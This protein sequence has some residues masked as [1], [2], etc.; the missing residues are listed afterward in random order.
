[1]PVSTLFSV[2]RWGVEFL[3]GSLLYLGPETA[4]PLASFLAAIIGFLLIGWRW[5]WALV[6]RIYRMVTGRG[7]APAATAEAADKQDQA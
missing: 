3:T 4:L 6:K 2:P 7:G 5:I 1:M